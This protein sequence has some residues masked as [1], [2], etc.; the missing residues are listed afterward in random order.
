MNN[1]RF[2]VGLV[3][4][5]VVLKLWGLGPNG[6]IGV[7]AG[8]LAFVWF[9][10]YVL[11][12]LPARKKI[13]NFIFSV[14]L[15]VTLAGSAGWWLY[16]G[17]IGPST[18]LTREALKA[19]RDA[20]DLENYLR[21]NPR[22]YNS[23][24]AITNQLQWLQDQLGHTHKAKFATI[25]QQVL[26]GALSPEEA[27]NQTQNL[28]KEEQEYRKKTEDVTLALLKVEKKEKRGGVGTGTT[29]FLLAGLFGIFGLIPKF[30]AKGFWWFAGGIAL[31]VGMV[32]WL[33]PGAAE[34]LLATENGGPVQAATATLLPRSGVF[35]LKPN[36]ITH[37]GIQY[38]EG[39]RVN[40]KQTRR[41]PV[42]YYWEGSK[43]TLQISKEEFN[44]I[45][46]GP[47]SPFSNIWLKGGDR[48]TTVT[49]TVYPNK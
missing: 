2:L 46:L 31:A 20:A 4:G 41:P 42:T 32:L 16:D 24:A 7:L 49:V 21:L 40:L 6:A 38:D 15:I 35:D 22:M 37:T 25:R 10:N 11:G 44:G 34:K 9:W 26:D 45:G 36:E 13:I 19:A 43:R 8:F 27:W 14:F 47:T 18:Q 28:L 17:Y 33:S 23:R 3:A 5:I 1:F 48:P 30:P 39:D 29:L 12:R